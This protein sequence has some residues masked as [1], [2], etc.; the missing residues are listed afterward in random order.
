METRWLDYKST[1]LARYGTTVYRIGVDGGFS[2]P[3]RNPTRGGGCIYCDAKGSSAP[4]QRKEESSYRRSSSHFVPDIDQ[5]AVACAP[6]T[7]EDRL[8]SI[9][10]QV[11]QG[12]AFIDSRYPGASKSIYFQAFTSTFDTLGNLRRLY[13]HA[14]STGSYRE[15]IVSTRP[16]CL[17][18]E[19]VSLLASYR[20]KVET[21][22]VELGLQSA[23]DDTLKWIGRGHTVD[24][25]IQACTRA[26]L[27]GLQVSAHVILG[28]PGESYAHIERTAQVISAVH[29][30][31]IKIHNL[32]VVAGTRLYEEY[33][34]GELSIA[35]RPRHISETIHL[36]RRIPSDIAIQR[37][38][39]DTPMHRLAAPRHFGDKGVFVRQLRAHMELQDV[40]Q[41]DLL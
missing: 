28:L 12:E 24:D 34:K 37:F 19:V 7:L 2:C 36:L 26:H 27:G 40:H 11:S 10:R 33:L 41:G 20:G 38:I 31:A 30:Q 23:N 35:S 32:H 15:L 25:F 13:D 18:E 6:Q 39:S 21:V 1:L 14:L 3:N 22:W 9:T 17:S 8:Q 16:D 5:I 4:Y 29:P